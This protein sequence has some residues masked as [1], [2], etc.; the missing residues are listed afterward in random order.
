MKAVDF[1]RLISIT[2]EDDNYDGAEARERRAL[3]A[4]RLFLKTV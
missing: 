1:D 4:A 3:N 2:L